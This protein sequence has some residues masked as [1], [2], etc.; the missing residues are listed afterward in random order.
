MKGLGTCEQRPSQQVVCGPVC[1]L[2]T[3]QAGKG[4]STPV[5]ITIGVFLCYHGVHFCYYAVT[6]AAIRTPSYGQFMWSWKGML[7]A[8][9]VV[10]ML[11][12]ADRGIDPCQLVQPVN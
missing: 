2:D 8:T 12:Y 6:S 4:G 1:M 10:P 11:T 3:V 7:M 5:P 9:E